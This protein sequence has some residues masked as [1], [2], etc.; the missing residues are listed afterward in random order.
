MNQDVEPACVPENADKTAIDGFSVGI[1]GTA[2]GE[3]DGAFE[4]GKVAGT[5]EGGVAVGADVCVSI[6]ARV[7]GGV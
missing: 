7:G 1:R 4:V 6:G 3:D 5:F 2:L